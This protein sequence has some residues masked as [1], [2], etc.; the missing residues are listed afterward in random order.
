MRKLGRL[1]K[2]ERDSSRKAVANEVAGWLSTAMILTAY[3]A[4]LFGMVSAQNLWY[5]WL[6][7]VGGAGLAIYSFIKKDFPLTV[8]NVVWAVGGMIVLVK[9]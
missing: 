5:I 6:N 8:V 7:I 1:A 4:N 2:L 3:F 9:I